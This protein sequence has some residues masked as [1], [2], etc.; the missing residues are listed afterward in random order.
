MQQ[1]VQ[2]LNRI[3]CDRLEEKMKGTSVEGTI[4]RLFEGKVSEGI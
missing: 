3:L 1:D 2:E 4:A